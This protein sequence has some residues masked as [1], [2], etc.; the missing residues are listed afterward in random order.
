MVL[1]RY[2]VDLGLSVFLKSGNLLGSNPMDLLNMLISLVTPFEWH[3]PVALTSRA[4]AVG[5]PK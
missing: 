4:L 3:I 1:G 2:V 5:A